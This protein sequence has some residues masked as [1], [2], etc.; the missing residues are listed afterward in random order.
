MKR[1]VLFVFLAMMALFGPAN[2]VG[3]QEMPPAEFQYAVVDPAMA[4]ADWAGMTSQ[5]GLAMAKSSQ[6][7]QTS[8]LAKLQE[9]LE[10]NKCNLSQEEYEEALGL[11]EEAAADLII[12]QVLLE[13]METSC[14][15]AEDDMDAADTAYG[16]EDYESAY[17]LAVTALGTGSA[18]WET[19]LEAFACGSSADDKMYEAQLIIFGG[20]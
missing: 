11:L 1:F 6:A 8:A 20:Q 17:I 16:A 18:A 13:I 3:A 9:D 15:S 7:S 5:A 19:C 4:E 12:A 14:D 2:V 10:N